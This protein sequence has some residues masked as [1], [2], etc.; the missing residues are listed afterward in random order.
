MATATQTRTVEQVLREGGFTSFHR[1][2]VAITG[3]AWTFVA[4]E[5]IVISL[6][7][8]VIGAEFG[9]FDLVTFTATDPFAYGLII[10]ATLLGSFVGSLVLGRLSD[11][12]GRRTLF[13]ACVVEALPRLLGTPLDGLDGERQEG[14]PGCE[15]R[16]R[17]R[18]RC[19]REERGHAAAEGRASLVG[20]A[21]A[22]LP[23]RSSRRT[24]SRASSR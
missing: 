4:F 9:I 21:H 5:I 20:E 2:V 17:D 15:C 18:G 8:P 14:A 13:Q 6:V 23:T 12:Y 22:A 24:T 1:R 3:F 19:V 10:S 7:L 16:S 11:A